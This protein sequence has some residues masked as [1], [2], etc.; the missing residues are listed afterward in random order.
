MKWLNFLLSI[1]I[2]ALSCLPCTDVKTNIETNS[3]IELTSNENNHNHSHEEDTCP[4]FCECN[5]CGA[6]VL[7]YT[8]LLTFE[9]PIVFKSIKQKESFYTS[10]L[11]SNFF[12]SIWQ[13]PQLV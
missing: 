6:Q 7:N 2:T 11:S 5:C 9:F 12:G 3:T 1:Y 8:P 4:P 13:P 10:N